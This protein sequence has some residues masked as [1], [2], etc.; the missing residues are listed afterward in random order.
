MVPK[1]ILRLSVLGG[2]WCLVLA[3]IS[4]HAPADDASQS[5]QFTH[6]LLWANLAALLFL[7][8]TVA[9]FWSWKSR[10]SVGQPQKPELECFKAE[11]A[12]H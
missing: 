5:E 7:M 9:G 2:I 1:T 12:S 11:T 6:C 4:S 10:A 3:Y 8:A